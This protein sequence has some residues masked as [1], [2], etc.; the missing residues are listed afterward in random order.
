MMKLFL[1]KITQTPVRFWKEVGEE[2]LE[3]EGKESCRWNENTGDLSAGSIRIDR[4]E[5]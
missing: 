5:V 4:A 2:A 3:R 1:E